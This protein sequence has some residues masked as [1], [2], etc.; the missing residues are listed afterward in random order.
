MTRNKI[1]IKK[2][3]QTSHLTNEKKP[4]E[5]NTIGGKSDFSGRKNIVV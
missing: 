1:K 5:K 3:S 4:Q 2:N